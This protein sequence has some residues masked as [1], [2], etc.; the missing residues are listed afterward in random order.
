[1]NRKILAFDGGGIRGAISLA[2]LSALEKDSGIAVSQKADIL[3]GTSTGAI[4][5]GAL[6]VGMSPETIL[7][8]Y[9]KLSG[10]IFQKQHGLDTFLGVKSKYSSKELEKALSGVI[11]PK[12]QLSA[13]K[14]KVII[15]TVGLDDKKLQRWRLEILTNS[16]D[17]TLVDAIMESTA[18]PT[19]FPSFHNHIDGGMAANDPSMVAYAV[20]GGADALLSI[21]T[22]Y[23]PYNIPKG[24]DW[25]AL[26]WIV[27]LDPK[28]EESKTPLLTMLFDVQD[29]L[30]G[31]LCQLLL[32]QRYQRLNLRLEN[33]VSLND[34]SK[35]PQ[36]IEETHAYIS[37]HSEE[38]KKVCDWALKTFS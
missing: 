23:T 14:R 6:S 28:K 18:A 32:K 4:I 35:I 20:A 38:W 9:S 16:S 11:D 31:E 24:E 21:G 34:V 29:Q 22:G 33:A 25:G 15:P 17:L 3:A 27:D 10:E 8:F 36:L 19:Y 26:S 7:E 5:V 12:I 13:L 1:M 2:F 37:S 30:P